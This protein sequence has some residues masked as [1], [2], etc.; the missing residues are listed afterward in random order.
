[1]N[2]GTRISLATITLLAAVGC[3]DSPFGLNTNGESSPTDPEPEMATSELGSVVADLRAD[4]NRD[5]V[6]RFD[7][8]SDDTGEDVWS[9]D[10]GAVFLANIDDDETQCDPSLDDVDVAACNDAWDD[11]VNGPDDALDLARLATKPWP[12]APFTASARLTWTAASNVRLFKVTGSQFTKIDSG[13]VLSSA[14]IKSGVSLAIEGK[15]IVRNAAAWDGF[16]DLTLTVSADG[17]TGSDK[18]RMRVAPLLTYH[19]GLTSEQT[20]VSAWSS[21]GNQAMRADLSDACAAAGVPQPRTISTTDAWAQDFFEPGFMSMPGPNGTQHVIRVNIRS[22]N[23]R[24]PITAQNPLRAAGRVVWQLRGKDVAGIQEYDP[25]RNGYHDSLNSFGNLETVPPYTYQG[26][27]Y[28]LGRVIR[29]STAQWHPDELFTRMMEAQKVQPPIYIDTSW[30][31]VGHVDESISFVKAN[32]ARGWKLLVNDARMAKAMLQAQSNAGRGNVSMF[33]GKYWSSGN[34]AQATIDEVLSD[35]DVM[36]ASADAAAEVD[37]QLAK[38]KSE[39][40]LTD[41]EIIRIPFLHMTLSG[42]SIAY[43]PGIVNG[44]YI[45]DTDFVAPD[46]H[47][48][49]I[50]GQDIFKAAM[51]DALAPVGVTV[52]FAEDWDTYHAQDGEVHC[53]TNSTRAIPTAKWWESGR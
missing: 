41:A 28:P 17:T 34:P 8:P 45:S 4:T 39:T 11:T 18:V 42:A 1:M 52:H 40:G 44:V 3:G 36:S 21:Q 48:P 25:A 43:Q 38:I 23:E 53:G 50:N 5:G 51:Q 29:G 10:H 12:D 22:A 46:P 13:Y 37:G 35:P 30:L 16:V 6:V 20:W 15:D 49:V 7:D 2:D 27:S 26:K 31:L 47:G 24:G 19:H 33:V 9:A 14:E 32:T